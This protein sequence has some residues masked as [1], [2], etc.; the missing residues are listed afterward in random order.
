MA[1]TFK[2]GGTGDRIAAR[3]TIRLAML[4]RITL[5]HISLIVSHKTYYHSS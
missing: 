5:I 1:H 3:Y 2:F 4:V